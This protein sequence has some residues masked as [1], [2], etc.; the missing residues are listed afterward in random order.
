MMCIRC[1]EEVS[2]DSIVSAAAS[3]VQARKLVIQFVQ[4]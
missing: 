2:V 3:N 4:V 1:C